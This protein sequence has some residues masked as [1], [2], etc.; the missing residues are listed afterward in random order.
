MRRTTLI[1]I[2]V[3]A[4]S[5]GSASNSDAALY[6]ASGD[7]FRIALRV[8]GA[9][10]VWANVVVRLYCT[11]PNGERHFNRSKR[12]YASL[13]YPIQLDRRGRFRW[14]SRGRQEEG[15]ALEHALFGRVRADRVTGKY[16][17]FR[18]F[19]LAR[20]DVTC[21]TNSYR[22]GPRLVPFRARRQ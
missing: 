21:Q 18:S 17:Y 13:E 12:N 6:R 3:L 11:R 19:S 5:L 2:L 22:F 7:G 15:F 1:S 10:L 20:R 14:I 9:K 4:V 16:E 8:K